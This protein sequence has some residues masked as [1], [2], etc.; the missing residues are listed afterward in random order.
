MIIGIIDSVLKEF[1][2]YVEKVTVGKRKSPQKVLQPIQILTVLLSRYPELGPYTLSY[3]FSVDNYSF[4][5]NG[6]EMIGEAITGH[7]SFLEFLIKIFSVYLPSCEIIREAVCSPQRSLVIRVEGKDVLLE[8]VMIK[9]YLEEILHFLRTDLKRNEKK[10]SSESPFCLWRWETS[11]LKAYDI[12]VTC[13]T[14]IPRDTLEGYITFL[15]ES[16]GIFKRMESLVGRK[17]LQNIGNLIQSINFFSLVNE[18]ANNVKTLQDRDLRKQAT[19]SCLHK[20]GTQDGVV[21]CEKG[22]R[23]PSERI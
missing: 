7:I 6:E 19:R 8:E 14:N 4:V 5:K 17:L 18:F 3:S 13:R 1:D 2:N 22:K 9:V 23:P 20:G 12:I 15:L 16:M 21:P 10:I 11:L